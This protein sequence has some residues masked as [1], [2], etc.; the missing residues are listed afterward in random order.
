MKK[1]GIGKRGKVYDV[2]FCSTD[3]SC[4]VD[5]EQTIQY[6]TWAGML[7]RCYGSNYQEKQP[8]YI[9]CTVC[10][11]WLDYQNFYDWYNAN[12]YTVNGERVHLDKDI[13]NKGNK[14]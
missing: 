3:L 1:I 14:V 11:E 13:L 4:V 9:G 10:E 6:E 7:K 8:S 12:F 2:G 5:G